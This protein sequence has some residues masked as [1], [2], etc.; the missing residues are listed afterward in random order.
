M[1]KREYPNLVG[2]K[3]NMLLVIEKLNPTKAGQSVWRCLCDCG[4]YRNTGTTPLRSGKA[5]SC[6]C[7][8]FSRNPSK[9]SPEIASYRA[10]VSNY[11]SHAARDNR[12]FLLTYEYAISLLK[13]N[14][15]YCDKPPS[16]TYNLAKRNRVNANNKGI[17]VNKKSDKYEIKYSGIDR[18]DNDLDYIE[19]NV[20]SCCERCNTFK[21]NLLSYSEMV[22]IIKLLKSSR[23]KDNIWD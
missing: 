11:K 14:C 2:S 13:S 19:G 12:N 21:C 22:E 17:Y 9:Y 15:H 20:V 10:K 16:N 7:D 1:K 23:N 3:F 4:N 18:K 5:R 8:N 6:G